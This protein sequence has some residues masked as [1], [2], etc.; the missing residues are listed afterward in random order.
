MAIAYGKGGD[1][2]EGVFGVAGD[3]ITMESCLAVEELD[4][5]DVEVEEVGVV[6]VEAAMEEAETAMS[7]G[8]LGN[9]GGE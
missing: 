5:D 1:T 8:V 2:V 4:I 3:G 9:I 6:G 7:D